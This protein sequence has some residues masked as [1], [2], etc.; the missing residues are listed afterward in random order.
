MR[1]PIP[2]NTPSKFANLLQSCWAPL[3]ADRPDFAQI[4]SKLEKIQGE[5]Q[6]Y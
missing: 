2:P 1:L 6:K 5:V 3:P 4:M